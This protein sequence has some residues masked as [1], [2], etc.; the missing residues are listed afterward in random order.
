MKRL[1]VIALAM[2]GLALGGAGAAT[3]A[4]GSWGPWQPTYQGPITAPAGVVCPFEVSA[5]PV[6]QSE[7]FRYHYDDTGS[8]DGYQLKGPLVA[9]ITN[10][11]TGASLQ[12]NLASFGT[13]TF[14]GDGSYDAV[15]DGNFLVFFLSGESPSNELLLLTGRTVLHGAST[16]EKTLV[17]TTGR[18]KDLCT[19]LA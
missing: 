6:R 5:E 3:G 13:V 9:R 15:V 7:Q 17:S 2:L 14:N 18:S 1:A 16:G 11:A 12:R 4:S 10:T 8:V 19:T